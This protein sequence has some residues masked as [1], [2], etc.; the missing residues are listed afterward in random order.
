MQCWGRDYRGQL[1][2]GAREE[3]FM[4]SS[5]DCDG[6]LVQDHP[7]IPRDVVGMK[8][9]VR[10]VKTGAEHSCAILENGTVKCWG[11]NRHGQLGYAATYVVPEDAYEHE[12][13]PELEATPV[14]VCLERPAVDLALGGAHSCALLDDGTVQ[15]W[16][17]ANHGKLG[18]G[19]YVKDRVEPAPIEGLSGVIDVE[20]R[21]MH[22]C[23]LTESG[24]LYCWGLN[25]NG[26]LGIGNAI[27]QATPQLVAGF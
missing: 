27:D 16:G 26:Q 25:Y 24:Q 19:H 21:H 5:E 8:A 10:L 15:C 12:R 13:A 3:N 22:T 17:S 18:N 9:G 11:S 23:A 4:A 7:E 20:S 1:G 2:D 6:T 14:R